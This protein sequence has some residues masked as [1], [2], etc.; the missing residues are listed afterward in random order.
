MFSCNK[1]LW[2]GNLIFTSNCKIKCLRK[3]CSSVNREIK[4]PKSKK[5]FLDVSYSQKYFTLKFSK[6]MKSRKD[7]RQDPP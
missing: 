3:N 5:F 7:P 6:N 4:P 2:G 1:L